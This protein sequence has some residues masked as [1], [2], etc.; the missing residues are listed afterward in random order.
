MNFASDNTAGCSS[1]I[2]EALAR[3]NQGRAM[4]YGDD[5]VTAR[6][7]TR[8]AELFE[9]DVAAFPVATGTAAN[10]LSLAL[11][12]PAWGA[13]WCHVESHVYT[14]EC[15][16]PEF[17]TG[18]AKLI[19]LD[20][21]HARFSA[22]A[23]E[24][25]LAPACQR[26]VHGAVPSAVSISQA[27]EAGAVYATD[28]IAAISE[29]CRARGLGLHMDGARF[30]NALV[31]Q[32]CSPAEATWKS[33]VDILSFGATKNG[34]IAAEAVVIFKES[35]RARAGEFEFRRKRAGH[36]LS[37]MRFFSVQFEAYLTDDLWL[38]NARHSNAMAARLA[39]GLSAIPGVRLVHPV[40]ANELF[41]VLPQPV[42]D[43]L[44]DAGFSFY[45]WPD[46]G[47]GCV[48]LICAFE[49]KPEDVDAF[50]AAARARAEAAA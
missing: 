40:E 43:G 17:Y 2:L 35:L 29:I 47:E 48:R 16:A 30:A 18:G 34:A 28:E 38:R 13:V 14:D 15:A 37:K 7:E 27:S 42:S 11:M 32:G 23:L 19:P 25:N 24:E 10:A 1:E 44:R 50:V 20:G 41:A 26:G 12:A 45:D 49:T 21:R 8:L 4:P 9:T 22:A 33:G 5:E 6:L 36:L 46:G 31:S 39:E 3:A